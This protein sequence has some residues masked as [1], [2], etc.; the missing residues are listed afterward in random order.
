MVLYTYFIWDACVCGCV[1][2]LVLYYAIMPYT[3][4]TRPKGNSSTTYSITQ[5]A[6]LKE[7]TTLRMTAVKVIRIQV[8]IRIR[9]WL[10]FM[11]VLLLQLKINWK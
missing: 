5:E 7:M 2:V 4:L 11:M 6:T 1:C 9:I 3:E 10:L 8:F